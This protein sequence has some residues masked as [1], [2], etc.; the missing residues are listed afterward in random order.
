MMGLDLVWEFEGWFDDRL[1]NICELRNPEIGIFRNLNIECLKYWNL[2]YWISGLQFSV[3]SHCVRFAATLERAPAWTSGCWDHLF[4]LIVSRTFRN[5]WILA[6]SI[7]FPSIDL[8]SWIDNSRTVYSF[9]LR[10]SP[11]H[12]RIES[13]EGPSI[14]ATIDPSRSRYSSRGPCTLGFFNA[15]I[16]DRE[17]ER[18]RTKERIKK[19]PN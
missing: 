10:P 15:R 9:R 4:I 12:D 18:K 5:F 16:K 6:V 8:R 11:F 7:V 2:E 3:D 17:R 14:S 1:G 19:K 13:L